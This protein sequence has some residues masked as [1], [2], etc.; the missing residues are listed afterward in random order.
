MLSNILSKFYSDPWLI[1]PD[2]H[3][4]L[5]QA[6]QSYIT[7]RG[8]GDELLRPREQAAVYS[9]GAAAPLGVE[10]QDGFAIL[11]ISGVIGKHLSMMEME[12]GGG[13]DIALLERQAMELQDRADVHTV[14]MCINS[15][16]GHAAGVAD[17][18][19]ILR[20]LAE[21]KRLVAYCDLEADS[22]GYYL[23]AAADEIYAPSTGMVGSISAYIALVDQSR[24]WEREGMKLEVFTDGDLKLI[25]MPGKPVLEQ[26]REF[27]ENRVAAVGA[28]FKS[29]I[30]SRRPLVS[31]D[32]MQ[33]QWFDG[34]VAV[35]IGLLDGTFPSLTHCLAHLMD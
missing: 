35:E 33:G 13:Y 1:R 29:F 9:S 28:R 18:A 20:E 8:S 32:A 15:P 19:M 31:E 21:V 30:R 14:V 5:G 23:A 26:E 7:S 27:L 25:G 10:I 4:Q 6:L 12:C 3:A 22:A 16:G 2:K 11:R 34:D 17:T 24:A